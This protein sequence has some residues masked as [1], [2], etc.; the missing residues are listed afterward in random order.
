MSEPGTDQAFDLA[1]TSFFVGGGEQQE[2]FD[3]AADLFCQ[4]AAK[5][6]SGD[7]PAQPRNPQFTAE[8]LKKHRPAT[9]NLIVWMRLQMMPLRHTARIAQV[10]TN[11]VSAIDCEIESRQ[12]V[13]TVRKALAGNA[14]Y[15]ARLSL[16][17]IAEILQ[18]RKQSDLDEGKLANLFKHLTEKAE[19][20]SG[21]ATERIEWKPE[22][23]PATA[24]EEY[25]QEAEVIQDETH[26]GG[27]ISG[28][29]ARPDAAAGED[30]AAADVGEDE[31]E[32]AYSSEGDEDV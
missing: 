10:S 19:L 30:P 3:R 31:G 14:R 7:L 20:L 22:S 2:L 11:T 9:Y 24:Y 27:D 12:D 8:T 17:R 26:T 1:A 5:E 16:E 23:R 6:E 4:N 21:N 18:E 15:L 28:V 25:I 13:E 29:R 32:Q